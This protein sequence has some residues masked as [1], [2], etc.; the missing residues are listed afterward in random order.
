MTII[1]NPPPRLVANIATVFGIGRSPTAPG[2]AGSAVALPV[3]YLIALVAG[4]GVLLFAAIL[5]LGIGS[6]AC[7]IYARKKGEVDPKECVIDE[8]AGQ[9]ITCAFAPTAILWYLVAFIL[10]RLFDIWK[11]WPL[12]WV[13]R[14]VPGGLGIMAD[15][16]VAA[17]MGSIIIAVAAHVMA[18]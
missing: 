12:K 8:V 9:W 16:V 2:T 7:E 17:L 5:L 1:D 6:W 13:E 18:M 14:T 15:D 3:A 10:F 4:R 11:P